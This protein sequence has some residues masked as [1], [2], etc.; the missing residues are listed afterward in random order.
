MVP[1]PEYQQKS[2]D[3]YFI[4]EG[5]NY[6]SKQ[7]TRR[8]TGTAIYSNSIVPIELGTEGIKN[9]KNYRPVPYLQYLQ[10]ETVPKTLMVQ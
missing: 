8:Q 7:E 6:R 4:T 2:T 5:E 10:T 1:V 3:T 9:G